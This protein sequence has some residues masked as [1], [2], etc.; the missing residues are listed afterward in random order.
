LPDF[1]K[2]LAGT[3]ADEVEWPG[4][5]CSLK[6]ELFPEGEAPRGLEGAFVR[7]LASDPGDRASWMAYAD[8]LH[9]QGRP[10]AG[11]AIL[12]HALTRMA[13]AAEPSRG[14]RKGKPRGEPGKSRIRVNDHLAVAC[15]HSDHWSTPRRSQDLYEQMILF[16]DLWAGA[17][18]D[19]A[20]SMV[21]YASRWDPLSPG[22]PG[23]EPE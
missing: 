7:S 21:R 1:P 22:R 19:L 17:H 10:G 18:S 20:R 15:F 4:H 9:E 2:W 12:H 11:A 6:E 5:L 16:D 14:D 3:A 13:R 8:W 23:E